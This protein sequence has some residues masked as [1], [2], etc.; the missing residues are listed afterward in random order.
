MKGLL[1]KDFYMVIKYCRTYLLIA[2][3]FM[4]VSLAGNENLFL[5]FYP[6][7]LCGMIP[8]NLLGYD[9]RSRWLQYCST[10]PYTKTQF[11]SAKYLIGLLSQIAMLAMIGS[12]QA[13]RMC[14]DGSFCFSDYMSVLLLIFVMS[15]VVSSVSHP[16]MFKLGVEKGR[17]VYLVIVGIICACGVVASN[18]SREMLQAE[19]RLN[20]TL[21]IFCVAGILL[22][23]LSWYLS[24]LF[25][26]KREIGLAN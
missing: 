13:I 26:R 12:A 3:I 9:E 20:H 7:M 4:L 6:C 5:V 18:I 25:F 14:L 11:V 17:I 2:V 15:T 1:L 24:V 16:F 23:A 21:W 22:Y 10:L 8:T 19:I